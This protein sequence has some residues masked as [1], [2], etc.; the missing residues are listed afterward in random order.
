MSNSRNTWTIDTVPR[1]F[2]QRIEDAGRDAQKFKDSLR[3]LSEK[4]I[5][6]VYEQYQGLSQSLISNGFDRF[7]AELKE[8]A[9]ETLE[10]I[11]NWVITQGRAYYEDVLT[12]P[13]KFPLEREIRRP[14][15]AGAIIQVYT[16]KFGPWRPWL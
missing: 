14:I 8:E 12:H 9:T 16:S 4:E 1:D 3:G 11:A 15:F 10:E 6:E 13:E 2:W 5:R 7:P